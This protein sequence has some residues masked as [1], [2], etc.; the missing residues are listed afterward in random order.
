MRLRRDGEDLLRGALE[1]A[2]T[3]LM[4]F[5]Y[6]MGLQLPD[7]TGGP[8][9]TDLSPGVT[10]FCRQNT[11]RDA[12]SAVALLR[13]NGTPPVVMAFDLEQHFAYDSRPWHAP[14][15]AAWL[16]SLGRQAMRLLTRDHFARPADRAEAL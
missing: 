12:E 9:V 14:V 1:V 11:G 3:Y 13:A 15:L 4:S 7:R 8:I 16:G 5:G 2:A 6:R 10:I